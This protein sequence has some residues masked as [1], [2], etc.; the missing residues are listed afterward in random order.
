MV[1]SALFQTLPATGNVALVCLLFYLVFGILATSLLA[2]GCRALPSACACC[3]ASLA[4]GCMCGVR[5]CV[6]AARAAPRLNGQGAFW[7]LE[8]C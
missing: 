4:Q 5:V 1:V 8:A 6:C 2:V 7:V 3:S